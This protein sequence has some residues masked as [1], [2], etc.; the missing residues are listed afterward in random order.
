VVLVLSVPFTER[1]DVDVM[2]HDDE[3]YLTVGPYRRSFLLPDSLKR[4]QVRRAK[5]AG[6]ELRI[7]F[8]LED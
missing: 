4:R 5:L 6:S 2:R 1:G 3:L 8:G 7:S